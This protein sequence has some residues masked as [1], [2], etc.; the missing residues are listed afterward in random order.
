[1]CVYPC[2]PAYVYV[3]AKE[4]IRFL[5]IEV[6]GI[7]GMPDFWVLKTLVFMIIH[8]VFLIKDPSLLKLLYLILILKPDGRLHLTMM[9]KA[10]CPGGKERS[11]HLYSQT[12][13]AVESHNDSNN[14][15]LQSV[16]NVIL[17][18]ILPKRLPSAE[19]ESWKTLHSIPT[20]TEA[21]G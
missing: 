10:T 9:L 13:R 8:H 12:R 5:G 21:C 16:T 14:F 18:R 17:R 19:A 6:T 11:V 20:T 15:I 3:E 7:W 2:L 4:D 1:M